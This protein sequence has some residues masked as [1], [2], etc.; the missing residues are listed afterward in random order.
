MRPAERRR[1]ARE[2]IVSNGYFCIFILLRI[3]C[4]YNYGV[5]YKNQT[6]NNKFENIKNLF[7]NNT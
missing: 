6:Q 5:Q 3:I 1:L 7:D 2:R 4:R